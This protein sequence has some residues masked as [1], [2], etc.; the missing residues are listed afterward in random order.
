[1]TNL[2]EQV[3]TLNEDVLENVAISDN[4]VTGSIDLEK[5]KILCLSIPFNGGWTAYANGRPV[6][7]LQVNT[8]YSGII[9]ETGHYDIELRYFTPGF[10]IG[11]IGSAFGVILFIVIIIYLSVTYKRK[12]SVK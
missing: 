5:N 4:L 7:L 1:M 6:E 3:E 2:Q 11:L 8:M 12:L 9:L 10:K